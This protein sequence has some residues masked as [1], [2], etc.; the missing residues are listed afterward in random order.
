MVVVD[1]PE[2]IAERHAKGRG[3]AARLVGLLRNGDT[4]EIRAN[5]T[6]FLLLLYGLVELVVMLGEQMG[7]DF[8]E[9]LQQTQDEGDAAAVILDARQIVDTAAQGVTRAG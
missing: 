6:D 2:V 9:W 3:L 7:G 1:D 8:E 5:S 4:V